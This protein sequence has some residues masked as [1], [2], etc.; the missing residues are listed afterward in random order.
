MYSISGLAHNV[1]VMD[2]CYDNCYKLG[3]V[4]RNFIS[5]SVVGGRCMISNNEK[6]FRGPL[7]KINFNVDKKEEEVE[8]LKVFNDSKKIA[9]FDGV[10]LYPS[11]MNR[12]PGFIQGL[13]NIIGAVSYDSIKDKDYYFVEIKIIKVGKNRDFS[14]ISEKNADGIRIFKNDVVGQTIIIDK[15]ALEDAIEFQNIEFDIIRGYTFNNGFNKQINKTIKS[16]FLARLEKKKEENPI[17]IVYK[18]ILNA[19]YGRTI[20]KE[21]DTEDKYFNSQAAA[22]KYMSRNHNSAME[23]RQLYNDKKYIVKMRHEIYNHKNCCHIGSMILSMSK[24][25]MNEVMCTAEDLGIEIFYQDTDSMHMYDE[26]ILKLSKVYNE[27]YGRELIGEMLGQFHTDFKMKVKNVGTINS[28]LCVMLGKK[29]YIDVLK[30]DKSDVIE[31]HSRLKGV[32]NKSV[33]Y[34][35]NKLYGHGTEVLN[36][37]HLYKDLYDGKTIEFDLTCGGGQ[38]CFETFDLCVRTKPEFDREIKF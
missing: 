8:L 26:D 6:K 25:I 22:F 24:R 35:A 37:I 7:D 9:D 34:T 1:I 32:S 15:I 2:G 21:Q 5:K 20:M 11:A 3:G 16:M 38:P 17:Q 27:K 30:G 13:P 10:S 23:S 12:I 29:C 14:L 19:G 18:L 28:H 33:I 31:C 4:I 36:M